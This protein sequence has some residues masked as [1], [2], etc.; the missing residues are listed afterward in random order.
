MIKG[1][2]LSALASESGSGR[3]EDLMFEPALALKINCTLYG[4]N[5]YKEIRVARLLRCIIWAI[6]VVSVHLKCAAAETC[7]EEN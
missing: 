3:R 6:G 5:S 4:L 1:N 2:L 7:F